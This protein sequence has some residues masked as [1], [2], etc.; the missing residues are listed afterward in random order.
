MTK[1]L[2]AVPRNNP[3]TGRLIRSAANIAANPRELDRMTYPPPT[4]SFVKNVKSMGTR[5]TTARSP[6]ERNPQR[7]MALPRFQRTK[8]AETIKDV[9]GLFGMIF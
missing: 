6:M 1:K 3:S 7:R 9:Q 2:A 5:S 4:L 8:R